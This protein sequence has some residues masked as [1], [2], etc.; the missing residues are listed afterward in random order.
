M[1]FAGT[2]TRG[3]ACGC[4]EDTCGICEAEGDIAFCLRIAGVTATVEFPCAECPD[5]NDTYSSSSPLF[6]MILQSCNNCAIDLARF[7]PSVAYLRACY[8][9]DYQ[10]FD[11][12]GIFIKTIDC[13]IF[14][15]RN[16]YIRAVMLKPNQ[17]GM[18]T[19]TSELHVFIYRDGVG[20][21]PPD[22]LLMHYSY[23]FTAIPFDCQ[24]VDWTEMVLEY[25]DPDMPENECDWSAATLEFKFGGECG[26]GSPSEDTECCEGTEMPGTLSATTSGSG[27]DVTDAPMG[28][29]PAGTGFQY[30][31][32]DDDVLLELRC[33]SGEASISVNVVG[34]SNTNVPLTIISCDPFHAIGSA[35]GVDVEITS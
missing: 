19:D 28:D 21:L 34:G 11:T 13:G 8:V 26:N 14:A 29:V 1:T 22:R 12:H 6:P 23:E 5:L 33:E 32:S 25:S 3:S 10:L 17:A 24:N 20:P 30:Q 31:Y 27:A 18:G 35:S 16:Y 15:E 7:P 4:C 9:A 2:R